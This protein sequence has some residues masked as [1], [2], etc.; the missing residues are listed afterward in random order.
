MRVVI[1]GESAVRLEMGGEGF[2]ITSEGA[3]ISPY[4]MLAASLASCTALTVTS[5]AGGAGVAFEQLVISVTWTFSPG[6]PK[7]VDA[8]EQVL[9]W[10]QL[11]EERL[12]AA[13]RVAKLCPIHATINAGARATSVVRLD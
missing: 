8:I 9:H 7:R 4:H 11:P 1:E 5:W 3:A 12:T 6:Q 2:E 13:D 10:P